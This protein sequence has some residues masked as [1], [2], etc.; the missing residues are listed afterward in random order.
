MSYNV[1]CDKYATRAAYPYCP[2]I[3][4][5]WDNRRHAILNDLT[6]YESDIYALQEVY[7]FFDFLLK[8]ILLY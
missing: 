2:P 3:S 6:F 7:F 8:I 5:L 4:L 1:L